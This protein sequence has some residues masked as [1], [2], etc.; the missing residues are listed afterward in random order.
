[1]QSDGSFEVSTFAEG[2]GA[3]PGDYL[4]TAVWHKAGLKNGKPVL[5]ANQLPARYSQPETSGWSLTVVPGVNELPTWRI[6]S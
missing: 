2:D 3:P 6:E 4:V 1:M 5:S